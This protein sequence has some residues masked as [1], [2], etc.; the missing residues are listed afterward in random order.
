V[1]A[2]FP[3]IPP[4]RHIENSNT[5][6]N[7]YDWN[8]PSARIEFATRSID[9][10]SCPCSGIHQHL[11]SLPVDKIFYRI[12]GGYTD[13]G[14][15]QYLPMD[16]NLGADEKGIYTHVSASSYLNYVDSVDSNNKS[17]NLRAMIAY[18]VVKSGEIEIHAG[19]WNFDGYNEG[20]TSWDPKKI[21]QNQ[22]ER[23]TEHTLRKTLITVQKAAGLRVLTTATTTGAKKMTLAETKAKAATVDTA[24]TTLIADLKVKKAKLEKTKKDI[25]ACNAAITPVNADT[26]LGDKL[27]TVFQN[28][29]T[30]T[31]LKKGALPKRT[32]QIKLGRLLAEEPTY[33]RR[34][35]ATPSATICEKLAI[36]KL[37]A[38]TEDKTV[39]AVKS[40]F[41]IPMSQLDQGASMVAPELTTDQKDALKKHQTKPEDSI[42]KALVI[43]ANAQSADLGLITTNNSVSGF[44]AA[45][46]T[47]DFEYAGTL[48]A[49]SCLVK[50]GIATRV[51]KAPASVTTNAAAALKNKKGV[52]IP[53]AEKDKKAETERQETEQDQ[54]HFNSVINNPEINKEIIRLILN[55]ALCTNATGKISKN[56]TAFTGNESTENQDKFLIVIAKTSKSDNEGVKHV[57]NEKQF[58]YPLVRPEDDD[59]KNA[60]KRTKVATTSAFLD[61]TGNLCQLCK[62]KDSCHVTAKSYGKY[63]ILAVAGKLPN[64]N[65]SSESIFV[66]V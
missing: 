23:L 61:Y 11:K 48:P 2:D 19:N 24:S 40:G 22:K 31:P 38:V 42:T 62:V 5:R 53:T 21:D 16:M 50:T 51:I 28:T 9:A 14:E 45:T 3:L 32:V 33:G 64:D 57:V 44:A 17:E 49:G 12:H 54:M 6:K 36:S 30:G 35:L 27:L 47:T 26:E 55:P 20:I 60:L 66:C 46:V 7:V 1:T 63:L 29:T 10:P 37:Q 8:E 18:T 4:K 15:G 43:A 59:E 13:K 65:R 39:T 41:N 52:L 56:V 34:I 25:D 58:V